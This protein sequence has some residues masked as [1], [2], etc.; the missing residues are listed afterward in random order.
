MSI[1]LDT[2]GLYGLVDRRDLHHISIRRLVTAT[3]EA[4]LVPVS[5]LPELDHLLLT[6]V[7]LRAAIAVPRMLA[8]GELRLE[9]LSA[10][11]LRRSVEL[12]E[13]YAD[14]AIGLVDASIVAMAERLRI[15]RILTLDRRHFR[16]FRPRHCPAFEVLP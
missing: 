5:V 8:A 15:T 14:N 10:A 16:M 11:D 6:R 12:M 9:G 2:S 4:L 7:G 3:T 13:Q 1:L